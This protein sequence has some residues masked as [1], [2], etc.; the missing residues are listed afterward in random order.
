MGADQGLYAYVGERILQGEHPYVHAWDQKPPAIHYTYALMRALWPSDAVVPAADLVAAAGIG[1]SLVVIGGRLAA[2]AVGMSAS[3]LF[4]F[5]SNPAFTRLN[6]VRVRAQCETFVALAVAGAICVLVSRSR[7]RLWPHAA[8]GVLFGAAFAF[9]YNAAVYA[10]VAGCVLLAA[11]ALTWRRT[12]ALVG[13]AAAVPLLFVLLLSGA[14]AELYEA[15]IGYNLKYSGETYSGPLHFLSY[16]ATFPI[17]R[18]RDDALWTV[19]GAGCVAL[20][21]TSFTNPVRLIPVAWVATACLSIAINGS[22]GLPQYFVQAAPALALAAAWGGSVLVS[23]ARRR[24]A[25]AA[26]RAAIALATLL[27]AIGVWRVNQFP[28]LI[29]QTAFDARHALGGVT[30]TLY[31][32]RYADPR[33]YSALGAHELGRFMQDH[34]APGESVYLFGFSGAAYVYADRRSASRFFWSRPVIAGFNSDR[35][36]YGPGGVRADLE[37]ARPAVVALQVHDWEP[38]VDNSAHY[39]LTTPPLG[40]WLRANY[41]PAAGPDGFDVWL[42]RE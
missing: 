37:R 17:D 30:R 5:L 6:G 10:A 14:L 33:K 25:P 13:G 19:G 35:P 4:L 20:L 1:A 38:D 29:E 7:S 21:A 24:L 8:A 11:R 32:A 3:L 31:L 40:D 27:I 26:R 15:T 28:K 42:R 34:S 23:A 39:F 9:K 36:D 12:A 22:R 41:R 2:P 16:L 18:A